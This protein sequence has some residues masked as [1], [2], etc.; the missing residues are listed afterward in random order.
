MLVVVDTNVL[1]SGLLNPRG[2]PGLIVQLILSKNVDLALDDRILC[3]YAEVLH[4]DD[5]KLPKKEVDI[6][7][8]Y[9]RGQSVRIDAVPLPITLP[10]PGDQPFFEVATACAA[11]FLITG[12]MKHFPKVEQAILPKDF[13]L[14][15]RENIASRK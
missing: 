4:R 9:V 5:L 15:W 12:N 6:L 8:G 7:L 14:F 1:V 13:I 11:D 3:E 10:D 2:N